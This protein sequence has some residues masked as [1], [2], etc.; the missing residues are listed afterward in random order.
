MAT[1]LVNSAGSYGKNVAGTRYY[2]ADDPQG[3]TPS[4]L[5]PLG[6]ARQLEYMEAWFREYYEDPAN[7]TPHPEGEFV[8]PWGGP[9]D[10][11]D[12][13]GSEFGDL[14]PE[15]RIQELAEDLRREHIDWA[16]T[17]RKQRETQ[18]TETTALDDAG[19][20][21][22]WGWQST[23]ME[24]P[25]R[26]PASHEAAL[27]QGW[28]FFWPGVQ[29]PPAAPAGESAPVEAVTGGGGNVNISG[30]ADVPGAP[31]PD[32]T[33]LEGAE[34][35]A[36]AR[37][38]TGEVAVGLPGAEAK[39]AAGELTARVEPKEVDIILSSSVTVKR[40]PDEPPEP[41][42]DALAAGFAGSGAVTANATVIQAP[43][44]P[45][46]PDAATLAASAEQRP[47][48]YRFG[49]RDGKI[50]VLPEPPEPEDR[51]FA[52]DTYRELVAKVREMHERLQ[53]TNSASRVGNS[54]GRLLMA[55][56]PGFDD[57][58]PGVL[59][60]R[61]RSLEADR[62]AFGDELLPDTIAMMDDVGRTLRDLLASFP[63]VR[64][65]EAEVLALDLDRSA[66]AIPVIREQMDAIQTVAAR[67]GFVTAGAI[68]ALTQNDAAIEDATDPVVRTSLIA[69]K[70]LVVGNFARAIIGGIAS[71]GRTI[72][73]ELGELAGKSWQAIKDE[74]PKG[75]GAT[76]RIAPL[77]GLVTLAGVIAGPAASI[78]SVVPAYKPISETLKNA[79]RDG[80]KDTLGGKAKDK[81]KSK[82]TREQP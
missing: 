1:Y 47:A 57:L 20:P 65:I 6:R 45:P 23:G 11:F 82:R 66:D 56:G 21:V 26:R 51:E 70:L 37:S 12:E 73:T 74:L 27:M 64:R 42:A 3:V 33:G 38:F 75:I 50:D 13:L 28:S 16:P 24:L 55:L 49:L 18:E 5:K 69:D 41:D 54:I 8:Y 62:A 46:E 59:L 61:S 9:Y 48:A 80:L 31:R 34:A 68:A 52:L 44:E 39:T 76:A 78:A 29:D 81:P 72:G 79:I 36:A 17:S 22:P 4:R 19:A 15:D 14:V 10:A 60:S 25:L 77:V 35:R 58:R 32:R 71:C 30:T 2:T 67:S 43:K 63:K 7:K 40:A 53:G